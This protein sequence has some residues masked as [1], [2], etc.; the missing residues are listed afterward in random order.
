MKSM[1]DDPKGSARMTITADF[2]FRVDNKMT[3]HTRDFSH[4]LVVEY[5]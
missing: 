4:E 1:T 5:S 2:L 3:T